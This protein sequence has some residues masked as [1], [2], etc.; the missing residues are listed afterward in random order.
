MVIAY[1]GP[2]T[3]SS[4]NP[5]QRLKPFETNA[6]WDSVFPCLGLNRINVPKTSYS[7]PSRDELLCRDLSRR[8]C[9][10]SNSPQPISRFG[11]LL[12]RHSSLHSPSPILAVLDGDNQKE[13]S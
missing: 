9:S 3:L 10:Q 8:V 12:G 4:K 7:T 1:I 5:M 13:L 6:R 11:D 2:G